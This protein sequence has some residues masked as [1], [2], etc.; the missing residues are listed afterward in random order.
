MSI[1]P[2]GLGSLTNAIMRQSGAPEPEVGMG[3]TIL[4]WTDRSPATI[5]W[6]AKN[7]KSLKII[8]DDY[9]RIDSNGISEDQEYEYTPRP[10]GTP[11]LY[12]KRKNGR[13]VRK[14]EGL[15]TGQAIRIGTRERYYDPCF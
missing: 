13:W 2:A 4:M 14:G 7:G 1:N 10:D 8:A 3:A 9:K 11:T 15:N 6:V 5:V 12:T